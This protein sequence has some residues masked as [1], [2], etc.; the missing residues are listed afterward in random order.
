V[1]RYTSDEGIVLKTSEFGEIDRIVT[2]FTRKRGKFQ[3]IAKGARKV[4]NRFGASLDLFSFS[5]FLL[6]TA[7]GMPLIVQG[8][9]QKLFRGLLRTP[10]QWMAG[11]YLLCV[12][13]RVFPFER[14]EEELL[15]EVLV[16]WEMFLRHEEAILP[17]L[18]RFRLDVAQALGVFPELRECV[19]CRK[20]IMDPSCFFSIASGG[21]VCDSCSREAQR[22][23]PLSLRELEALRALVDTPLGYVVKSSQ[24]D[25]KAFEALDVLVAQ[26]LSY[27]GERKIPDFSSFRGRE[28]S[29]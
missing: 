22:L 1:S 26:Y 9:I 15:D 28:L 5:E 24:E 10:L 20:R 6:Y 14:R 19:R 27:Q 18:V 12:L 3:A 4:G 11:E 16:L 29:W 7:S 23:F 21:V 13:D 2:L 25:R 17:L 8:K